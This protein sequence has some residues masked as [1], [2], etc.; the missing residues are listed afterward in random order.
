MQKKIIDTHYTAYCNYCLV[1]RGIRRING[2]INCR[3][4]RCLDKLEGTVTR[5]VVRWTGEQVCRQSETNYPKRLILSTCFRNSCR[6]STGMP[7]RARENKQSQG[8]Y[9]F[10]ILCPSIRVKECLQPCLK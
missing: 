7:R 3:D 10:C 8:N 4:K 6:G 9:S 5:T 2:P 1:A